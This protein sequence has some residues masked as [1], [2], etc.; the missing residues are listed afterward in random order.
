LSYKTLI[1]Q[2][3]E[4]GHINDSQA[5]DLN[6][7]PGAGLVGVEGLSAYVASKYGVVGLTRTAAL[8][9]AKAGIRVSAVCPG[10][11][12]TPMV[13]RVSTLPDPQ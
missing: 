7:A 2:K 4:A 6:T 3:G 5:N 9:Y 8:E 12:Q 11:V 10:I 13:E 1:T